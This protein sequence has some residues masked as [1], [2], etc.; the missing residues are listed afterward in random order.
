MLVLVVVVIVVIVVVLV[1]V[2]VLVL[3]VSK[4]RSIIV[5]VFTL[6]ITAEEGHILICHYWN[7]FRDDLSVNS[8]PKASVAV[9]TGAIRILSFVCHA[10]LEMPQFLTAPRLP[11]LMRL[12]HAR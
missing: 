12:D 7:G 10:S 4:S 2:A 3:V 8:I 9:R 5:V 11:C 6:S 1:I